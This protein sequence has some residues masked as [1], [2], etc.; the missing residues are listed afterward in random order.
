MESQRLDRHR[1]A[2]QLACGRCQQQLSTVCRGRHPGRAVDLEPDVA[3]G[4]PLDIARVQPHPHPQRSRLGGPR[5]P[6]DRLQ[7]GHR[8]PHCCPRVFE[9]RKE[10]V[11]LS[12]C[13]EP[14]L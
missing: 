9:C 1:V 8:G 12:A 11:A 10:G 2:S 14:V 5:I 13:H 7:G 3:R 6:L 4:G